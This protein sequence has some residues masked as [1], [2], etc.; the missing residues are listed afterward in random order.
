ME[1][2]KYYKS[3]LFVSIFTNL[4]SQIISNRFFWGEMKSIVQFFISN[5][6]LWEET[7]VSCH[8]A[9][10]QIEKLTDLLK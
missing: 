4:F 1:R 2:L 5:I 10:T 8:S 7:F 3:G 6:M 9:F